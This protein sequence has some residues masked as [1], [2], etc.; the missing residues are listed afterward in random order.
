MSEESATIPENSFE[1]PKT[2]ENPLENPPVPEAPVQPPARKPGRPAG[3][4]D[5][6]PRRKI[7]VE[8]FPEP[9][10]LTPPRAESAPPKAPPATPAPREPSPPTPRTLYRQTSEHLVNLRSAMNDQRRMSVAERY[11]ANLHSWMA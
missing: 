10:E 3:S 4:K 11:T 5:R 9:V 8:P 6:V 1:E 2:P 7:R